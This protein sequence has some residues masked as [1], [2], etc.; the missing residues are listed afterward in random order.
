MIRQRSQRVLPHNEALTGA[1]K[2]LEI[3]HVDNVGM[4]PQRDVDGV[5]K[6]GGGLPFHR[7]IQ[8]DALMHLGE[9]FVQSTNDG[10]ERRPHGLQRPIGERKH[11][12]HV[13]L[14]AFAFD[15]LL[16]VGGHLQQG[17]CNLHQLHVAFVV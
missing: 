9:E 4:F 11:L 5:Q 3:W 8:L 10:G 12:V 13:L 7:L 1:N 15:A 14:Q 16:I 2:T 6:S 17:M